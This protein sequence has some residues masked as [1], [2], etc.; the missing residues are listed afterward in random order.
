LIHQN[1]N[2]LNER[3]ISLDVLRGIAVLGI[4]WMNIQAFAAPFSSY[5]NPMAYGDLTGANFW[6][7]AIA[8]VFGEFKFMTIFSILFGVGIV[9]FYQ[10]AESKGLNAFDLNMQRMLWLMAFGMVHAYVIW[11]GDILFLY[12]V[13]GLVVVKCIELPLKKL[14]ILAVVLFLVPVIL[15]YFMHLIFWVAGEELLSEV[16]PF[17]APSDAELAKEIAA[18]KGSWLQARIYSAETAFSIQSSG[19]FFF[20]WRGVACMLL[21][22]AMLRTGFISAALQSKTYVYIAVVGL[23]LGLGLSSIGVIKNVSN[24]FSFVYS[25]SI[26]TL[27]N[28]I[29]SLA[30]SV[31]YIALVMLLVKS[32]AFQI[33]KVLLMNVGKMALSNYIM[34][35]V[36]ATFIFYGFGLGYFGDLSR[37]SLIYIVLL[38][39]AIQLVSSSLWL[40]RFQ[41]GPLEQ[42]WRYLTYR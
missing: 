41:Q 40:S 10:R 32:K 20:G 14:L 9:I 11:F 33:I 37:V 42:L 17:W 1:N 30:T 28:Y 2:D 15:I 36:I 18:Y 12:A 16:M 29:G 24:Q 13:C 4:F 8:H 31:A 6:A 5:S 34:Q 26:G 21:G 25:G 22:V 3:I 23:A 19:L 38:V 35:S 27:Y 7:W 39:W